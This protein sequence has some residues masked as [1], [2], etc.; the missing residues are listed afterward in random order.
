MKFCSSVGHYEIAAYRVLSALCY[1][2]SQLFEEI[3]C[4]VIFEFSDAYSD[5]W[6]GNKLIVSFGDGTPSQELTIEKGGGAFYKLVQKHTFRTNRKRRTPTTTPTTTAGAEC[7][8]QM[9]GT[10]INQS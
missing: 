3:S 7:P 2:K 4:N 1:A 9:D 8:Q 6:G 5:V 10:G